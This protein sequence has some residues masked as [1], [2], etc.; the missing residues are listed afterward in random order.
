M[1]TDIH[2][3]VERK[4]DG[5]WQRVHPPDDYPA[6]DPYLAREYAALSDEQK[7]RPD[8]GYSMAGYYVKKYRTDWY[9]ERNYACFAILADVRNGRGF[10]G[11]KT[12]DGY[13]PITP[14]R[15]VPD[16]LSPDVDQDRDLGDHSFSWLTVKE[17]LAYDWGRRTRNYGVIPL[18]AYPAWRDAP[19]RAP[20]GYSHHVEGS[21][22]LV[23]DEY[24]ADA[25]LAN[26]TKKKAGVEYFVRV[27]WEQT[28]GE[29]AGWFYSK[30]LPELAKIDPEHP[31][32]VR[33][34]F[35]FDS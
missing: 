7:A 4:I 21:G 35:G 24:H 14:R 1:G 29:D 11:I 3:V 2:L 17:L 16:D 26:P 18:D 27:W 28:Y 25:L 34:V 10:A 8:D 23:L 6:R 32:D 31:D 22:V 5:V 12:G 33:I 13:V 9:S 30:V 20:D 15:G 19:R